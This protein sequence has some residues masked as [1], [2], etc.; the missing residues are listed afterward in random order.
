MQK[1]LIIYFLFVF[2]SVVNI[3]AQ[4]IQ[5]LDGQN[6]AV[7]FAGI[8]SE[9]GSILGY[10]DING[11]LPEIHNASIIYI[12]HVSFSPTKVEMA[13]VQDNIIRLK[14]S[15]IPLKEIDVKSQNVDYIH[16][17]CFYRVC[18]SVAA[19]IKFFDM[20]IADYFIDPKKKEEETH[21]LTHVNYSNIV[22]LDL[23][24][25]S[26][27]P[28]LGTTSTLEKLKTDSS[29]IFIKKGIHN[30]DILRSGTLVGR[31]IQD[32]DKQLY[33]LYLDREKIDSTNYKPY[34][35]HG[36]MKSRDCY[37]NTVCIFHQN[38][39]EDYTSMKDFISETNRWTKHSA[40]SKDQVDFELDGYAL[41]KNYLTKKEMKKKK[42]EKFPEMSY[43][44]LEQFCKEH[45]I[46]DMDEKLKKLV[47]DY[48]KK[49]N[50]ESTEMK[51]W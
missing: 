19:K 2:C 49:M 9:D 45:Q 44:Q 28:E 10:T 4:K 32:S 33:H 39:N 51:T 31:V 6:N 12:S 22:Y 43:Q 30:Q 14:E 38:E 24:L 48:I 3:F 5:V 16:I 25:A 40:S 36:S 47:E 34:S 41:E 13:N 20:G 11:F 37:S 15:V 29:Y 8:R 17:R 18:L 23:L 1:K 26:I 46:P 35:N 21:L 50:K 7:A 42:R 27:P